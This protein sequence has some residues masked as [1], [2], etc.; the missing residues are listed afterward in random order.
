[1]PRLKGKGKKSAGILLYR[2][3]NEVPEIFLVHPGG[4][5]Y[6]KKDAGIWSIPKGEFTDEEPFVAAKR[7]FEEETGTEIE[8]NFIE[9]APIRLMS[10]KILYAW[11]VEGDLDHTLVNSNF[12][13]LE[14]PPKSKKIQEF[15]EIDRGEWFTV[16]IAK[17]KIG[18]S[19]IPI[20]DELL[21][22]LKHENN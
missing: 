8:G 2:L 11:A 15:P 1:M 17:Q 4:P 12:F 18:V 16:D 10:G 13:K 21:N 22:K 5:F 6:R 9:L 3:K 20:I 7:E 19:Q 14:W